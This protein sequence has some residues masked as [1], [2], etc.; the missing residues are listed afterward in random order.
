MFILNCILIGF[1]TGTA[2]CCNPQILDD[3]DEKTIILCTSHRSVY[4]TKTILYFEETT[5]IFKISP[6]ECL[7][8]MRQGRLANSS[9]FHGQ[10]DGSESQKM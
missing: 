9:L 4:S 6:R 7:E 10:I 3:S 2:F 5:F 1:Y 8:Q